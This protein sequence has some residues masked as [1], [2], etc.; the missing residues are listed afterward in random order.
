MHSVLQ[1]ISTHSVHSYKITITSPS[2][3]TLANI[4][5]QMT[6]PFLHSGLPIS[7]SQQGIHCSNTGQH[8]HRHTDTKQD[9]SNLLTF[10]TFTPVLCSDFLQS[11]ISCFPIFVLTFSSLCLTLSLARRKPH[12]MQS[13]SGAGM[14]G[15]WETGCHRTLTHS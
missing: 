15:Q 8:T 10:C 5:I 12:R 11:S 14:I 2:I 6:H 13:V 1:S 9:C 7:C 4:Q 3:V